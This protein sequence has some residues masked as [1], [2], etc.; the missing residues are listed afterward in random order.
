[1]DIEAKLATFLFP[2]TPGP[3]LP[4]PP[5]KQYEWECPGSTKCISYDKV[6]DG[7][8]NCPANTDEGEFCGKN[9]YNRSSHVVLHSFLKYF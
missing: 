9:C 4:P 6:C 8:N 2:A 1:M 3:T 7:T 5:C